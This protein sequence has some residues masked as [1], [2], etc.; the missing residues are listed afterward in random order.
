M[1]FFSKRPFSWRHENGQ[2]W[3]HTKP[4]NLPQEED[5][6][7]LER[8]VKSVEKKLVE[9]SGKLPKLKEN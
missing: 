9:Q 3:Q 5:I 1:Q 6:K 2:P 4:E 7:K 8:R